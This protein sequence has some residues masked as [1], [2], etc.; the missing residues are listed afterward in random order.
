MNENLFGI[1]VQDI[2]EYLKK[3]EERK[4]VNHKIRKEG[5]TFGSELMA[6][7]FSFDANL[8]EEFYNK[9]VMRNG[10]SHI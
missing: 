5:E 8:G 3:D 9:V 7:A 2:E 4:R 10:S 6:G 1:T